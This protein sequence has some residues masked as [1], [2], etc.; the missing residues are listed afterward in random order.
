MRNTQQEIDFPSSPE[1]IPREHNIMISNGKP[2]TAPGAS[3]P[4]VRLAPPLD[5][6]ANEIAKPHRYRIE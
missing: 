2:R 4:R 6:P 3:R 1:E 5:A